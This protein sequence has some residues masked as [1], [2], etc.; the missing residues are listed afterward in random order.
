MG[1]WV[2]WWQLRSVWHRILIFSIFLEG[3]SGYAR[4]NGF[5]SIVW[6][7]SSF[8]L[9]SNMMS[10]VKN[11]CFDRASFSSLFMGGILD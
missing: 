3:L 9:N 5:A 2:R 11:Q 6:R 4:S 8:D 10:N 1:W 7:E